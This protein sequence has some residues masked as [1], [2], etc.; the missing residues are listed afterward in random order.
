MKRKITKVK[1][2]LQGAALAFLLLVPAC[3]QAPEYVP[4]QPEYDDILA[5]AGEIHNQMIAHYYAHRTASSPTPEL[6]FR[7]LMDLSFRYLAAQGYG[8]TSLRDARARVEQAYAP[9]PLKGT[10]GQGFSTDPDTFADQLN[11]TGLF[12]KQFVK[13][14]DK[15]L[16]LAKKKNDGNEIRK[17]VNG[18]FAGVQFDR[19]KDREAQRLFIDIFNGSCEYWDRHNASSLKGTQLKPSSWVIINDGIGGILGMVFGPV[20]SIV[21][22]TV[23]SV[24]TNEEIK[25]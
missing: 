19:E 16:S 17:Y 22:A 12:S 18:V 11:A 10:G 14:I 4:V 8:E 13:E 6:M 3:Q 9:S 25:D 15:L 5:N 2:L 20:G 24:G 1:V 7:E 21:T 23:F